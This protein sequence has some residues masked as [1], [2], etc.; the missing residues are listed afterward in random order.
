MGRA[1]S[2]KLKHDFVASVDKYLKNLKNKYI[3][4]IDVGSREN[5][6]SS[7]N[8]NVH[9]K[10][11]VF[12]SIDYKGI[13]LSIE[14]AIIEMTLG[15]DVEVY[16]SYHGEQSVSITGCS[17]PTLKIKAREIINSKGE[18]GSIKDI[19]LPMYKRDLD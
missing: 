11:E 9:L 18:L 1:S 3:E 7:F 10:K 4:K 5:L 15:V 8:L 16:N 19:E 17:E 2:E 14:S 13:N 6:T 12:S